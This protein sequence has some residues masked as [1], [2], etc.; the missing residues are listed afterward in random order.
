[1]TWDCYI[2]VADTD[3]L[4]IYSGSR[5]RWLRLFVTRLNP[6]VYILEI[7]RCGKYGD[8]MFELFDWM[9]V[10]LWLDCDC[11]FVIQYFISVLTCFIKPYSYSTMLVDT[12]F[13]SVILTCGDPILVSRFAG[14]GL[15]FDWRDWGLRYEI[16]IR[17][18]Q[19]DLSST[20]QLFTSRVVLFYICIVFGIELYKRLHYFI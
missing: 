8:V 11:L 17:S 3:D 2:P 9:R 19:F 10:W 1:M 16:S 4:V 20:V 6:V 13:L 18:R 7:W 12:C 5:Y 15:W 14:L